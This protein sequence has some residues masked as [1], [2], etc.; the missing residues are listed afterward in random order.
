MRHSPYQALEGR[1]RR[2]FAL[3][4]AEAFLTWDLAAMMPPGGADSRAEQLAQLRAIQHNLLTAPDMGELIEAAEG[5]DLNPGETANLREMRAQWR[6]AAA[7]PEDLVTELS[8][9]FSVCE[10]TWRAARPAS[11]F[12][13]ILPHLERALA[14]VREKAAI[15]AEALDVPP[16]DALLD[17]YEPGGRAADIDAVFDDLVAFLPGFLEEVVVR[18]A[19]EPTVDRPPGPFAIETQRRVGLEFM[20]QVGFD[21]GRGRLD[22]SLHP[23][24]GGSH[25]D[26]RITTRYNED[27]FTSSLMG[28]LHETGHALYEQGLPRKWR[29]QPAGDARGMSVH[30]SQSLLIE[31]QVCRS[32][33]FLRHAAPILAASFGGEGPAWDADNLVRLFTRVKPGFIRVDA[34]EVT[35]PAHVILRY[36]LERAMVETALE[37]RDLPSAWNE[38]MHSLLGIVPPDDRRGCLQDVH[39]YDGAWGY[40]PTYT[41][42]AM[43]A[44]QIFAAAKRADAAIE[45]GIARGDFAPLL[46]WLRANIHGKGS[47]LTTRDLLTE[48]TGGPLDAAPFKEHLRTRYLG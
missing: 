36:R 10:T 24:C 21:F 23:F 6:R 14:R 33:A 46:A 15:L 35:Y 26:V 13:A 12:A 41:L 38:G 4:D 1:F 2:L 27:D 29:D 31:M 32:A 48:A 18:Q 30:E 8:R 11:D 34:D 5:G 42:G 3:R 20:K 40:F 43:T 22:I 39:W 9:A 16:Y 17:G 7:L 44:A 45:P 37:A 47:L 25:E 19:G 28:V